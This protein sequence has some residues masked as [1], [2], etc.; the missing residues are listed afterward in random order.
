M[1]HAVYE[2]RKQRRLPAYGLHRLIGA[3]D[4]APIAAPE[5]IQD[6]EL[7]AHRQTG[8]TFRQSDGPVRDIEHIRREPRLNPL[9]RLALQHVRLQWTVGIT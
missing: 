7:C 5:F 9:R 2:G 8:F 1:M 3:T 6:G 4:G